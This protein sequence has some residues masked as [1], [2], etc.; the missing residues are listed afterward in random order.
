[1]FVNWLILI[2][3]GVYL[4]LKNL[5]V[6]LIWEISIR[7]EIVLEFPIFID[8]FRAMFAGT[9]RLVAFCVFTF[10]EG[11]MGSDKYYVRFHIMVFL[12]IISIF[13][14]I[15]SPRMIRV[16]LGWDG[17]GVTSYFLVIY[18]DSAKSYA[19]GMLTALRNR[20]GDVLFIIR[21]MYFRNLSSWNFF[22]WSRSLRAEN[23]L[24]VL[25][26]LIFACC[27]KRAQVPF[28]AWLPAAMAAPTPVSALV[29]SSTLVTAGV[30]V[31][32][33][34]SPLFEKRAWSRFLFWMGRITM[35]LAG[36][37][38]LREVDAKKIVA[39]STLRQLGV[40]MISLGAKSS[41]IA[42]FHLLSHAFFKALLFIVVGNM[43]HLSRSYQDLRV[44]GCMGINCGESILIGSICNFSLMGLPFLSGFYSK[45]LCI[46]T[47][48]AFLN[49][50]F[51]KLIFIIRV[52]LTVLYSI[53]FRQ[54]RFRNLN[55]AK[56]IWMEEKAHESVN[57]M[58][59]LIS[60]AVGGGRIYLWILYDT[61]L[62]YLPSE[63]KYLVLLTLFS[64]MLFYSWGV[65]GTRRNWGWE[66]LFYMWNLG[67]TS[68][69][70]TRIVGLSNAKSN[71]KILER[72]WVRGYSWGYFDRRFNARR[73]SFIRDSGFRLVLASIG[74]V[75]VLVFIF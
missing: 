32:F 42:F 58:Y 75:L 72:K 40:M 37:R 1:M 14:L 51:G 27:T 31:L 11:Y 49:N 39:L 2:R 25:G 69:H 12:F 57:G 26:I 47:G 3:V 30:Y 29:H 61:P 4:S 5:R 50:W 17:L 7:G 54:L 20:V 21:L 33:R 73:R 64:S 55:L 66:G 43:I 52:V 19:A 24:I 63:F 8:K 23:L 35:I 22:L 16:F 67:F 15:F 59:Y 10:S 46:E 6:Y 28:S 70:F 41:L 45:D 56:R 38:A 60:F 71:I 34:L 68:G 9:V 53:R 18:F 65:P 48:I 13:M 44:M 74:M 36:V 62:F